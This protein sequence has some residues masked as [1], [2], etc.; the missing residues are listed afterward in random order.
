[1]SVIAG[2]RGVVDRGHRVPGYQNLLVCDGAV[3][4]VKPGAQATTPARG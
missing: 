3:I 1:M 2:V 4:P